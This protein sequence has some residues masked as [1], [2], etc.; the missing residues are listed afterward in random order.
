M[1]SA[2]SDER[3]GLELKRA[4]LYSNSFPFI[5]SRFEL[6]RSSDT[7]VGFDILIAVVMS[8][9]I[10]WDIASYSSM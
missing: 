1:C 3:T 6:A 8:A 10:F 4:H 2:L 5:T 9:A 7:V